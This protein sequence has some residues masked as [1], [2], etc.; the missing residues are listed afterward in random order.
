MQRNA[1]GKSSRRHGEGDKR[2]INPKEKKTQQKDSI[3]SGWQ[4]LQMLSSAVL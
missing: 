1:L 4:G 3:T 2:M